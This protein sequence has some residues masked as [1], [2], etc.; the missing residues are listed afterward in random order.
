MS[1]TG[2]VPLLSLVREHGGGYD[3]D[4]A[5]VLASVGQTVR[6]LRVEGL[7]AVALA[8]GLREL[9]RVEGAVAVTKARMLRAAEG[10]AVAQADGAVDMV[11][12]SK[13]HLGESGR[14]AKRGVERGRG[15]DR[16]PATAEALAN[17]EIGTEQADLLARTATRGTLGMP[18]EVEA[19]LLDTAKTSS[20]ETLRDEVKRR[21]H[22]ADADRLLRDERIAHTRRSVRRWR[23]DDGMWEGRWL[24]DPL[25][26][27]LVDTML[28]AF[29][30]PDPS[31]TPLPQRRSP[32]QRTAD[33]LT[34]AAQVAL[35]AGNA[36]QVGGERPHVSVLVPVDT[37][38]CRGHDGE[39]GRAC[40]CTGPAETVGS[41]PISR[42]AAERVACDSQ[43]S[44][45][46]F[47][48]PGQVL[49]VGRATRT[50][51]G[52][53]RRAI[54]AEDGGCR[55]PGCDRP[56]AWTDIHHV[57]FWRN[58]GPTDLGNGVA[59]CRRHHRHVHEGGWRLTMDPTTRT[60]TVT[61]PHR[62]QHTSRPRGATTRHRRRPR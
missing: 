6:G 41:G 24:L 51:S 11:A 5:G 32:E 53:Q 29:T 55:F 7:D 8:A 58:G 4:V 26:G 1:A 37:L 35:D 42:Q 18:G 44:R 59:L 31:G 28:R 50:W 3:V 49:D 25:A 60:V 13:E 17:G 16:L 30:A 45:I 43:L 52:P 14:E 21:E 48:A 27:E 47:D 33:A 15:L 10:A 54:N 12:W 9:K 56:I 36:P 2:V 62:R 57:W 61:S 39:P 19:D 20:P 23:R 46:V 38:A 34:Q 22:A 40:T